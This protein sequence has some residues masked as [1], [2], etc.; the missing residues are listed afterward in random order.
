MLA[1]QRGIYMSELS[2]YSIRDEIREFWSERAATF[3]QS[4]GHEV[5]SQAERRGWHRLIRKHLGEGQKR[6]LLDLACGTAV[7]SHLMNDMGFQV[8]GLDW[9]DAML[10]QARAKAAK[11]GTDIRFII[12][13]AENTSEPDESYDAI[14]NRHLVWTLV[15]VPAAF[16]EWH[17]VLKPGGKLLIVDGNMGRPSWVSLLH[18]AVDRALGLPPAKGHMEPALAERHRRI[19]EQVYFNDGMPA[20]AVVELL[21]MAG[22]VDIVVDRNLW[23]IHLAQ[24]RK[25]PFWRA[26][27]RLASE[28]FAICATKRGS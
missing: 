12:R 16:A 8:T 21:Q 27:E 10:A 19:R 25:M 15:D 7:I 11:R 4:V 9:S 2:N 23:D 13:D 22:F 26:A 1:W 5:F 3:D 20:E 6:P 14:T 28:R 17:R 18:G 24:A